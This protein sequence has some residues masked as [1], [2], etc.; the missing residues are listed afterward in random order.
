MTLTTFCLWRTLDG[1][2]TPIVGGDYRTATDNAV[3]VGSFPPGTTTVQELLDKA[4][5]AAKELPEAT[6]F[7]TGGLDITAVV[8]YKP[9]PLRRYRVQVRLVMPVE[10]RSEEEAEELAADSITFSVPDSVRNEIEF[11][12]G[13]VVP[14]DFEADA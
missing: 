12:G 3:L 8:N 4:D 1:K 13:T 5:V 9:E 7:I 10:A 2:P 6:F 11:L 14:D